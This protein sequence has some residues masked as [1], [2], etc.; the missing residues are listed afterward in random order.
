MKPFH[1]AA[2][3]AASFL[4]VSLLIAG[5]FP[6]ELASTAD[7]RIAIPRA[8]GVLVF[9]PAS[10]TGRLV[11][12]ENAREAPAFAV[13]SRDGSLLARAA[14]RLDDDGDP[15][16]ASR[17][18]VTT[19]ADGSTKEITEV[20]NCSFLQ[21]DP[22][23]RYLSYTCI[24]GTSAEGVDESLP[25]LK[26]VNLAEQSEKRINFNTSSVH[27]WTA[28][29]RSIVY[30]KT[31]LKDTRG[32]VGALCVYDVESGKIRRVAAICGA[33]WFDISPDGTRVVLSAKSLAAAGTEPVATEETTSALYEI[34][35]ADGSF[36]RLES[37]ADFCRYSPDGKLVAIFR[38]NA[39]WTAPA[40]FSKEPA[41]ITATVVNL[42]NSTKFHPTW[43]SANEVLILKKKA[44][45]GTLAYTFELSSV[46]VATG[47]IKPLQ[48]AVEAAIRGR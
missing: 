34:L 11:L 23:G 28:D 46:N 43:I 4:A 24:G 18:L 12:K 37:D 25:E 31:D 47:E 40:D 3:M 41:R 48:D 16:S 29:G 5:C 26:L 39:L 7:G 33:E 14:L 30:L 44:I 20:S 27:R 6:L 21:L 13:I 1:R 9:D 45:F 22:R 2:T 38:E 17:I 19:L 32:R 42:D 10:G 15:G 35:L 36:R 8:E